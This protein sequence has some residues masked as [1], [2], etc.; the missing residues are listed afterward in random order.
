MVN[1]VAAGSATIYYEVTNSCGSDTTERN[2]TVE[3]PIGTLSITA[4]DK[5]CVS[6]TILATPSFAGGMWSMSNGNATVSTSGM[7]TGVTAGLDTLHYSLTNACGTEN[8]SKEITIETPLTAPIVTGTHLLCV[9]SGSLFTTTGVGG[10]WYSNNADVASVDATGY[11]LGRGNGTAVISYIVTNSCGTLS[12]TDTITIES[13]PSMIVGSDSVGIGDMITLTDSVL[14]GMWYSSNAAVAEVD[15]FSGVVSGISAGTAT[16]SYVVTNVCGTNWVSHVVEVGD[17][18]TAPII[19]GID[20]VCSGSS[21]SLT[22]SVAGGTW[23]VSNATASITADGVLTGIIPDTTVT[24]RYTITN[25]FGTAITNKIIKIR[26]A[27]HIT[28]TGPASV[29][30]GLGYGITATPA[31]GTWTVVDTTSS[32]AF[33]SANYFVI[34]RAVNA[35]L[36]YTATNACGTS[37]DT[38]EIRLVTGVNEVN[39]NTTTTVYPNPAKGGFNLVAAGLN[40]EA[41]KV[42][43]TNAVGAVVF[44]TS[45]EAN[46]AKFISLDQPAG[47]Y[48]VTA[49]STLGTTTTKLVIAQ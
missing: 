10:S 4:S 21:I 46:K 44:E 49:I 39:N 3:A 33:I 18:P 26:T 31:G 22:A 6:G 2:V 1:G 12:G 19:T 32:V 30:A 27:P 37:T 48:N 20:S 40:N 7:V 24:V 28:I 25:G 5:V 16:I 14:G 9:G 15:T 13:M 41:V 38:F 23:T 11:V 35:D 36:V 34:I 45:V 42:V 43:I 8:A 17:A 47:I 29:T